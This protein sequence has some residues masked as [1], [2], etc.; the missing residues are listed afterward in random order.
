MDKDNIFVGK[1]YGYKYNEYCFGLCQN[2]SKIIA[3]I[4]WLISRKYPRTTNQLWR[5][6]VWLSGVGLSVG[7][8]VL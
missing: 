5:A 1:I 4:Y 7:G 2:S 8:G 3:L 6:D